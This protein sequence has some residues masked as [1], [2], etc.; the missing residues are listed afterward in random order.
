MKVTA[1]EIERSPDLEVFVINHEPY[2]MV[3]IYELDP[4]SQID[5]YE[6]DVKGREHIA[7]DATYYTGALCL[8]D[9]IEYGLEKNK[10]NQPSDLEFAD[11]ES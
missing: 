11:E 10:K 6:V 7:F 4:E 5:V 9:A 1:E 3:A 8:E 2:F